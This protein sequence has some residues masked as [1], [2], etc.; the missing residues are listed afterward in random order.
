M[1]IRKHLFIR[2]TDFC[3]LREAGVLL[4]FVSCIVKHNLS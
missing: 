3:K 4:V 2:E 1:H